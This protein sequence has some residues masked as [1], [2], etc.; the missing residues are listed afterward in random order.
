MEH[1]FEQLINEWNIELYGESYNRWNEVLDQLEY[2]PCEYAFWIVDYYNTWMKEKYD[3]I[4]NLS[5]IIKDGDN[6]IG[7]W[8]IQLRCHDGKWT[9]GSNYHELSSPIFIKTCSNKTKKRW[10]KKCCDRLKTIL[11]LYNITTITLK[12]ETSRDGTPD[13]YNYWKEKGASF[14][15]MEHMM[16]V[17]LSLSYEQIHSNL[18]GRYKTH[19]NNGKKMWDI[20]IFDQYDKDVF[21][22]YMEF[23]HKIA[24][25][26]TRGPETWDSQR[27]AMK[28]GEAFI[29]L[30]TDKKN[31]DLIGAAYFF[32]SKDE[33]IYLSGAF[34]RTL[35][36]KPVSHITQYS[37]IEHCKKNGLK[38]YRIGERLYIQDAPSTTAKELS[39]SDFKEGFATNTYINVILNSEV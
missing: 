39:I 20:K 10:I 30:T 19:V 33:S 18:R 14:S 21:D 22:M 3:Q 24:G 27:N 15:S 31:G 38:N 17:D 16:Y 9:V 28:H 35:F 5:H 37:V 7:L 8:I 12:T 29:I 6:P 32:N 36:D 13:W 1:F 26:V 25:R 34:D 2:V 23:H 4:L 11:S